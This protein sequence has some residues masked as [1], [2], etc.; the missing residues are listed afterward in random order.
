MEDDV[1]RQ[2]L[3]KAI[4]DVAKYVLTIVV[5]GGVFGDQFRGLFVL[6]GSLLG[7]GLG[8]VGFFT[9]PMGERKRA[10]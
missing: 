3:G 1:R 10:S 4:L 7:V 9:L 8:A 2:E 5:I 6:G